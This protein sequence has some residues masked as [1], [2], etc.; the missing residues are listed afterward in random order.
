MTESR[1]V[2]GEG[3][4]G[5]GR[6]RYGD[7]DGSSTFTYLRWRARRDYSPHVV[8]LSIVLLQ[9]SGTR[10]GTRRFTPLMDA[11]ADGPTVVVALVE[12]LSAMFRCRCAA[13]GPSGPL[14]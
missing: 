5:Q 4:D 7:G 2:Q 12:V 3:R 14:Y 13:A 10:I 6:G 11:A 8:S 9:V 1:W